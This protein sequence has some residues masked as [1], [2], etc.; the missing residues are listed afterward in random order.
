MT[1]N[2]LLSEA[3]GG[4]A[5]LVREQEREQAEKVAER[6]RSS[7][8]QATVEEGSAE[9]PLREATLEVPSSWLGPFQRASRVRYKEQARC[10]SWRC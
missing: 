8:L 10:G 3:L 6:L 7:G 4:S 9:D 5:D 1:M 2:T